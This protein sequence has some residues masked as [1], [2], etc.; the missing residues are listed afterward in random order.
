[1]MIG[2]WNYTVILT[3][4]SLA[5]SA[6]GMVLALN[7]RIVTALVMLAFSGL[8]DAF[9]GRIARAKKDRTDSEIL[10]G[11]Q[12]DSLCDVICF[13][14]FPGIICYQLGLTHPI[15]IALIIFYCISAVARLAYYNMLELERDAEDTS[16]H[17][18]YGLPVTSIVVIFPLTYMISLWVPEHMMVLVWELILLI[19]GGL[20]I[21]NIRIPKP[22]LRHIL[23]LS[24]AVAALFLIIPFAADAI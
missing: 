14:L 20:F 18:Y 13:G 21:S 22:G 2:I 24:I 8:C 15:G 1:M 23:I 4:I 3:Y 6:C 9:D 12:L 19:T 7:G 5:S 10:F 11:I 17:C 16:P